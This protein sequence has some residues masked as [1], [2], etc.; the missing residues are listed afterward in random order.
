MSKISW[1]TVPAFCNRLI[2]SFAFSSVG[3]PNDMGAS[4][5]APAKIVVKRFINISSIISFEV[6]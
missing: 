6:F 1:M 4:M 3:R 5:S 2:S